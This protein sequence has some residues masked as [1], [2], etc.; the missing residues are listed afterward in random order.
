MTQRVDH[1]RTVA[2]QPPDT[3]AGDDG[4]AALAARFT[5]G[6]PGAFEAVVAR[7]HTRVHRLAYRLLGWSGD[8][9]DVVQD[10][11]LAALSNAARFRRRAD[12]GTWLTTITLN[13]CRSHRRGLLA[14]LRGLAGWGASRSEREAPAADARPSADDAFDRVRAA[15]L[16]L[17]PRE[18]E[19]IVLHYLEETPVD[20]MAPVL[21]L[22]RGAVEVRL[23]R[24]RA[25][26]RA[27]LGIEA[28]ADER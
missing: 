26:L 10:V 22:T 17:K 27:V 1:Q 18:R 19:V 16:Q 4:D 7:Y 25:R 23:H 24:A 11:F 6:E 20:R 2:D 8:A 21:G 9:D 5:R 13:K 28:A 3:H 12:L 15:L 14:R